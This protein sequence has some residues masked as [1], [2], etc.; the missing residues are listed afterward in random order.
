MARH[1]MVDMETLDTKLSAVILTIGAVVFD[2]FSD[3]PF[4][5]LYMRVSVED[6]L[7]A[8]RTISDSTLEWWSKQDPEIM[9]EAFG[10]EGRIP[11]DQALNTL[12]KFAWNCHKFWSHGLSYDLMVIQNLYDAHN[13]TYPW[14]YYDMRDTRTLFDIVDPEMP[15]ASKHNALEDAKRQ[16]IGVRNAFRKLGFSGSYLA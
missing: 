8:G 5:E 1:F 9:E 12:H 2:P 14:Q 11:L 7:A 13:K 4:Q 10:E 6:Q 15:Q 16:A 3:A